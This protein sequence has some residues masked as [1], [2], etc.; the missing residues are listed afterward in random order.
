M[1]TE[2]DRFMR[3]AYARTVA[4]ARKAFRSWHSSKI[5]DAIQETLTKMLDQWVRLKARGGLPEEIVGGLIRHAIL[6]VKYDRRVSGRARRP[7]VYDYRSGFRQQLL[8][9]QGEA[10]PS[11]RSAANEWIDWEV[12]SGDDPAQVAMALEATGLSLADYYA[13]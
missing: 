8:N 11:D 10:S 9:A 5:E 7:D 2:Q 3:L 4:A 12:A 1:E 13:A 6:F